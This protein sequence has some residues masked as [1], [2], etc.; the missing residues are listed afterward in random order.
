MG[1]YSIK[2][3]YSNIIYG[4]VLYIIYI[5]GSVSLENVW[6]FIGFDP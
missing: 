4:T 3:H 6:I 2:I 1:S 5:I